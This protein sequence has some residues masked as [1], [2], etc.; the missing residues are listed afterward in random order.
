MIAHNDFNGCKW[1]FLIRWLA[2]F[3]RNDILM[4]QYHFCSAMTINTPTTSAKVEKQSSSNI[5]NLKSQA[6][7]YF[8]MGN[9]KL[10]EW[11]LSRAL[12]AAQKEKVVISCA[13]V[14]AIIEGKALTENTSQGSPSAPEATQQPETSRVVQQSQNINSQ[15]L[16]LL[17]PWQTVIVEVKAMTQK[18]R[19]LLPFL[20]LKET[21]V[22]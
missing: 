4:S 16:A 1:D 5:E 19:E 3:S 21:V 17:E 10:G 15:I 11:F 12:N 14:E 22:H 18:I 8:K 6:L 13:E 20:Q 2:E 7:L 9:K